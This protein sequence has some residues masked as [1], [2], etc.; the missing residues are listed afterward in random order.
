MFMSGYADDVIGLH[1][2]LEQGTHFIQKPLNT[3]VLASKVRDVLD[4]R[5]EQGESPLSPG[6]MDPMHV[7]L[8]DDEKVNR[9]LIRRFL[10]PFPITFDEAENG[11]RA[12]EMFSSRHYDLVLMDLNM[13][14]MDGLAAAAEIRTRER[15]LNAQPTPVI[16]VTGSDSHDDTQKC[17]KAGFTLHLSKPIRKEKLIKAVIPFA[18]RKHVGSP[19]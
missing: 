13:P 1:G 19:S 15:S 12:I 6:D 11:N 4:K 8:V 7:L 3:A 10:D 18:Q 5:R 16:A 17:A 2:I 14:Q 9:D